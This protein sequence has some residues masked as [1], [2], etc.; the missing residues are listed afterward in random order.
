ML[1]LEIKVKPN[2]KMAGV[3]QND[4]GTLT[5]RVTARPVEGKAN[6]Q[7]IELLS[8]YFQKPKRAIS[9]ASGF[10]SKTKIIRVE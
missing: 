2:S 5:V 1:K 3:V 6:L 7:I 4:D 9:I 8:E 10:K